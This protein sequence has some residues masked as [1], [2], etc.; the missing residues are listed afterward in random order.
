[1]FGDRSLRFAAESWYLGAWR[2]V[3]RLP[4]A[5]HAGGFAEGVRVGGVGD[6]ERAQRAVADHRTHQAF[7]EQDRYSGDRFTG[8][9]KSLS[10]MIQK[11]NA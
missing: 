11:K 6:K 5:L 3:T 4:H 10:C 9:I 7:G 8:R 2:L 1:M